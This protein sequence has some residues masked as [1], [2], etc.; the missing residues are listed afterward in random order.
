MHDPAWIHGALTAARPQAVAALLRYFRDMDIAEEA[1]QE[2]CLRALKSWPQKGPPR[3]PTAWLI[4]VGRNAALDGARKRS[5]DVELPSPDIISD[6]EDAEAPLIDRLDGSHYRDDVLRLLFI[7]CHPELPA[8]QQIALA[9]RIVSGLTVAQIARAFLVSDAAMEQRITRAKARI[10]K[11][12]VP[13]ESP[14]PIERSERLA[15]VAAM[16]YLL[17]N[18]GYSSG[19]DPD[20]A[21]LCDEAIRLARLLLRL[22]QTEPEMMG[23]IALML[24]Q[25]SRLPARF[26]EDGEAVLLED[27]DRT[28]WNAKLISEGLA[29]IDKAM[30]HN[31]PGP[32]QVQAAIAAIHARAATAADTEW[33]GID[34]LYAALERMQPSPVI[35]LNRAVATAKL[36]GPEAGLTMIAPLEKALSGYFHYFGAR[37]AFLLQLGRSTEARTDFDRAIALAGTPAQAAHIRRHID[38]LMQE[39]R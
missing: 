35:T 22:F 5:R 25:Q 15:A 36:H 8:T 39:P 7:C 24:L 27:Q 28:R 33:A 21:P 9:L 32:Y 19:N 20:R 37:G 26:D 17:F 16:I 14:G 38:R 30:R 31:R 1:Y 12:D 34:A 3:D 4:L 18:E 6:L 11:A 10:A 23:L 2:A 29:L 13:F